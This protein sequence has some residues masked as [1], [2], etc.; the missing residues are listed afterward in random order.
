[1]R[2]RSNPVH[3]LALC[4]TLCLALLVVWAL[5]ALAGTVRVEMLDVGQG[6][7]ILITTPAGKRVLIDGGIK[8]ADVVD[9]LRQ[10]G[11][12]QLD[13]VVATHP[14]ADHIGGLAD[15]LA[16]LPVKFYTDNGL[17]HTTQ[18]YAKLMQM[19]DDRGITYRPAQVGQ[20]FH[21]DDGIVID[22]LFPTGTPLT[23]T[24][25]DLNA[26]SVVL[27]M[28][29]G[30]RCFLFTGD[31]EDPTETELERNGLEPC[32]VLK[33]AHHG[34]RYST[35]DAW[36]RLVKPTIALI[37]AGVHN[38]YGHPAPE[39]LQRLA[40]AGVQVYRTD[41]MGDIVITSDGHDLQVT[42]SRKDA[43]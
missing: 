31:S 39:T 3:R 43:E 16:A 17:P 27:R 13:L 22:V 12:T 23:G 18:V 4:L 15:V 8:Q 19:V 28:T 37:S 26:N 38:R 35:S 14:H 11:V 6:D 21:L 40:H 29:H 5:P 2:I 1:M 20:S 36:L 32:D 33:V 34:S 41:T 9:K 10:R 7:S 25:S 30:D 24:R 42:T